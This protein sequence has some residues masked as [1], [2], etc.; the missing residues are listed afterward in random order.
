MFAAA[1]QRCFS[2]EAGAASANA[3]FLRP[4]LDCRKQFDPKLNDQLEDMGYGDMAESI[5]IT[6]CERQCFRPA[7]KTLGWIGSGGDNYALKL[8]GGDRWGLAPTKRL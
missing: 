3:F 5:G 2:V 1:T 4:S 6:G 7:T 8:G